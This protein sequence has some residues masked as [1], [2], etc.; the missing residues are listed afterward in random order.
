LNVC[1]MSKSIFAM[2][3]ERRKMLLLVGATLIIGVLI[4]TLTSRMFGG[5]FHFGREHHGKHGKAMRAHRHI[6]LSDRIF[7][8]VNADSSQRALMRPI[9]EDIARVDDASRGKHRYRHGNL[10]SLKVKLSPILREEQ[11]KKL[12]DLFSKKHKSSWKKVSER[13]KQTPEP[14]YWPSL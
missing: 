1:L 6:S 8:A 10:D 12:E 4:G 11:K 9:I 14:E 3:T 5:H 2:T 13:T 7:S